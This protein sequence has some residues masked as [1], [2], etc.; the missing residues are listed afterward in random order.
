MNPIDQGLSGLTAYGIIILVN[1]KLST[2]VRQ[3]LETGKTSLALAVRDL[4]YLW[5]IL[6]LGGAIGH[7]IILSELVPLRLHDY[8]IIT[9]TSIVLAGPI[10]AFHL[11][12]F[13]AIFNLL[14]RGD[15]AS[16]KVDSFVSASYGTWVFAYI[17]YIISA[18][19]L[20]FILWSIVPVAIIIG[21][22][23]CR[24]VNLIRWFLL[25]AT[26]TTFVLSFFLP[27]L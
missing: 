24:Q 3:R 27:S 6:F 25:L 5:G 22:L 12:I 16:K 26:I 17:G 15:L 8:V 23:F 10:V 9:I 18:S 13:K 21:A 14:K 11:P 4:L 2:D 1:E 19:S 7:I 20:Y